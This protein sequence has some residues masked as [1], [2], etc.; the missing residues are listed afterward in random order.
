MKEAVH[1]ERAPQPV[2]AYS[3]AIK[4]NGLLFVSGQ[5]P[6]DPASGSLVSGPI[7]EQARRVLTS[8]GEILKASGT[9]YSRVVKTT[10]FLQDLVDFERMN[11]IYG[12]FFRESPPARSTVQVARLPRDA[13]VEIEAIALL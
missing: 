9:D 5:I 6:I 3:Q 13:K 1:T 10:V 4:A 7:E 2:G 8:L 12:E 11:S